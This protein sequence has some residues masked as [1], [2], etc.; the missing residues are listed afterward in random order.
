M[1][2]KSIGQA[3]VDGGGATKPLKGCSGPEIE[4]KGVDVKTLMTTSTYVP[5]TGRDGAVSVSIATRTPTLMDLVTATPTDSD[6]YTFMEETTFTNNALEVAEG[7]T[8]GEAA[9]GFTERT[10]DV[11]KVVV[12]LPVTDETLEDT[13]GLPGYIDQRLGFMLR[14]RTELQML[15]G[16]GTAPNMRGILNTAGIQTQPKGADTIAVAVRKARTKVKTPGYGNAD[17]LALNPADSED[18]DVAAA[19]DLQ[20]PFIDTSKMWNVPRYENDGLTAGTGLI[21]DFAN[22][23]ALKVKKAITLKVSNSH[24]TFFV[25]GKQAIRA[26]I[27]VAFV[28]F[29]PA[30][31][32]TI[33]GI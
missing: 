31:F 32:V 24:G 16:N 33:T 8:Y 27:R 5:D 29:R 25:E 11:S 12:W 23:T 26:E 19:V 30:A 3:F 7:G 1:K 28:I 13:A 20:A 14:Q 10:V 18:I 17:L 21:G 22:Y 4:V 9:L 6:P 15:V 2:S